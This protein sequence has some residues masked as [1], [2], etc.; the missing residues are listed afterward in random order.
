M[1]LGGES[2]LLFVGCEGGEDGGGLGGGLGGGRR[3]TDGCF[4]FWFL[5][6]IVIVC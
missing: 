6:V 5:I 3:F 4:G 2:V 1:R